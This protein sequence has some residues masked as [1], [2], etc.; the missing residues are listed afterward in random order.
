MHKEKLIEHLKTFYNKNGRIPTAK[1]F[2]KNPEY[3]SFAV[4]AREFGSWNDA[5]R[6]A[7]L[8]VTRSGYTKNGLLECLQ[9]FYIENG[10]APTLRDFTRK[11]GYPSNIN[12]KRVFG[13]WNNAIREANL[14]INHA[15]TNEQLTESITKF[16][17][18]NGKI[19]TAN[20]F[21][22]N[23]E[24]PNFTTFIRR[25]G[26]WNKALEHAGFETDEMIK[27]GMLECE[28][29]KGRLFEM[30]VRDS[31]KGTSVDSAGK[32]ANSPYDGICPTGKIYDAKS[33]GFNRSGW[34]FNFLN[35]E[36]EKIDYLYLGA[37]DIEYNVLMHVWLIPTS[38]LNGK[39]SI[40][41]SNGKGEY[42]VSNMKKY[43]VTDKFMELI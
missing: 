24:Y 28:Y 17:R 31:F 39:K 13:S 42:N 35:K 32:R 10:K 15:Y 38:F 3:P 11:S 26:S 7:G 34:E 29:H 37:F 1:D 12:Y 16:I 8:P 20:D 5:I 18:K 9:K 21:T 25:F 2:N 14:D 23:P 43:E 27:N 40:W 4:Y 33:S 22:G 41:I 19:P 6:S 30:K 36:I